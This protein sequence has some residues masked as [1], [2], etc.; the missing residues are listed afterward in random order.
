[1]SPMFRRRN[2]G[3]LQRAIQRSRDPEL[4]ELYDALADRRERVAALEL[5]LFEARAELAQFMAQVEKRL[6]PLEARVEE[7]DR[8][9]EAA[10]REASLEAQWGDRARRGDIPIDVL[11]QF[12]K[13]WRRSATQADVKPKRKVDEK[14]KDEIKRLYRAL[15][16]RFHPDLTVDPEHKKYCKEIMA[17][18]NAAYARGDVAK[19]RE[20]MNKPARPEPE[21]EKS[22]QQVLVE[23]RREVRRLDGVIRQLENALDRLA[24]SHEVQ[25]MLEASMARSEGRDLLREMAADLR[26]DIAEKEAELME[27]KS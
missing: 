26:R 13:T 20:L 1:M 3:A 27:I 9:L 6:G 18:V 8:K 24:R 4:A 12:K 10:R 11:E 15:A 22:R 17:E 14:S 5:E 21:E 7:L 25:L 23:L 2:S 19:L 16:K